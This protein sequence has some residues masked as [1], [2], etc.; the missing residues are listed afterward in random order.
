MN[1]ADDWRF[2]KKQNYYAIDATGGGATG[3]TYWTDDKHLTYTVPAG[4][5]WI[6]LGGIVSRDVSSTVSGSITN[7]AAAVIGRVLSETAATGI[8][9]WPEADYH[10]GTP[11]I[12]DSAEG[13]AFYFATSQTAGAYGS[14]MV[15]EL[16]V[17]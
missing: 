8:S 2:A 7:S 17:A 3:T 12:L 10:I 4:K 6:V 15:L 13:I 1:V 11:H 9:M 16:E 5:R 14:C